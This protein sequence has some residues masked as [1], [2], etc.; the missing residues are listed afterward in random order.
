V[1]TKTEE[2]LPGEPQQ[3]R[4]KNSKDSEK[5]KQKEFAPQTGAALQIWA[6]NA[7]DKISDILNP[8]LLAFYNKKNMRSLASAEYTEAENTKTKIFLSLDPFS[9]LTEE[10]VLNKLNTINSIENNNH[11]TNYTK[12]YKNINSKL[13]RQLTSEELKYTKAYYYQLVYTDV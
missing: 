12:L 9:Q 3:G 6:L 1:P 11:F 2:K 13:D 5:R 10:M 7:Q 4:P 8:H